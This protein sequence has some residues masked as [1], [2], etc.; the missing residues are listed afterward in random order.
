MGG[1]GKGT[2]KCLSKGTS[3]VS[4]KPMN[5][6]VLPDF[7]SDSQHWLDQSFLLQKWAVR[8]CSKDR[9]FLCESLLSISSGHFVV[10]CAHTC[11]HIYIWGGGERKERRTSCGV[12][13]TICSVLTTICKVKVFVLFSLCSKCV[14]CHSGFWHYHT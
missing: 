10:L 1:E 13:F 7:L 3:Q 11:T 9:H 4:G 2:K 6:H 8:Y 5:R 12:S 14:F